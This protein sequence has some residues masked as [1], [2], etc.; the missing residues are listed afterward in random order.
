MPEVR[1]DEDLA[2]PEELFAPERDLGLAA[3]PVPHLR[4]VSIDDLIPAAEPEPVAPSFGPC[5]LSQWWA[6]NDP[7]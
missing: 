1:T 7:S 6:E 5:R 4:L 3:A 2:G